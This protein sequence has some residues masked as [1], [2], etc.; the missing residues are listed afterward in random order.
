MLRKIISSVL[1]CSAF[2]LTAFGAE[3]SEITEKWSE[4]KPSYFGMEQYEEKPSAGDEWKAG[5]LKT[6]FVEDGLNYLNFCRF[7]AGLP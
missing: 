2:A 4:T 1:I 3:I 5:K 6:G 7:V